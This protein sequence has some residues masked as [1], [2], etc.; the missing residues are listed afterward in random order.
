MK[1]ESRPSS[2]RGLASAVNLAGPLITTSS[3]PLAK[4]ASFSGSLTVKRAEAARRTSSRSLEVHRLKHSLSSSHIEL[5]RSIRGQII[6]RFVPVAIFS[7]FG[8]QR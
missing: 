5:Q 3:R 4:H 7:D 6:G 2:E 1:P 8:I